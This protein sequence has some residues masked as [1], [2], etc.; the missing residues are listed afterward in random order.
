MNN[1]FIYRII[2]LFNYNYHCIG[3]TILN[4]NYRYKVPPLLIASQSS[5]LLSFKIERK[6]HLH[7]L[8]RSTEHRHST[9]IA[10][11]NDTKT[12]P[13]QLSTT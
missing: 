2:K 11:A 13:N 10:K 9:T 3:P 8:N 4:Q 6:I 12:K 5:V 7:F 1:A